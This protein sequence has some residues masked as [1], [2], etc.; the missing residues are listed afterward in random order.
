MVGDDRRITHFLCGSCID[1]FMEDPTSSEKIK[2]KNGR[3]KTVNIFHIKF[4]CNFCKEEHSMNYEKVSNEEIR[5]NPNK[6][7]IIY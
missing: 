4:M 5:D 6:C 1:Q 3:I 2:M 7:C